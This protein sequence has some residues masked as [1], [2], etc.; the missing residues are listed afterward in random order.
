M[1]LSPRKIAGVLAIFIIT[2]C[3]SQSHAQDTG[4]LIMAH[5]GG[6]EWNQHVKDAADPLEETYPVEFAWG[7]AN[8]VTLQNAIQQL[9]QQGVSHIVA[10]PLFISSYSPIIRQ[11]EYLFGM[12]DSLADRAMPLMHHTEEYVEMTEA[13]IDSSDYMHGMLMPPNLPQLDINTEITM[14]SALDNHDIVAKILYDRVSTLSENPANETVVIA[15]HGPS[16]ESDNKMWLQNME[17]L[18]QKVQTIQQNKGKEFKQIFSLTVRDDAREVI[19]DQAKENFRAIVR[20]SS[21]FGDVIVVP[22]F[23]SS[24]GREDA[25]AERLSGLDFKWSGRTLLP[26]EKISA[27]LINSVENALSDTSSA[28]R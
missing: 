12:R 3:Y 27:F 13:K 11:N 20:Q 24:S 7:M 2:F 17:S 6:E 14:T 26:D 25:V 16:R 18:S 23:L 15:A 5:G 28:M 4:I 1:K 9:E 21:Q 22:L 8:Y 10:I 19:H